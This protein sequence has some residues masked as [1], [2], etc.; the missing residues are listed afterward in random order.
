MYTYGHTFLRT[1]KHTCA[2]THTHKHVRAYCTLQQEE[3]LQAREQA[4]AN[5]ERELRGLTQSLQ[6]AKAEV[7][8]CV[9]GLTQSL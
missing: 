4:L 3:E 7:C 6:S 8:V 9:C 5:D 2:L 1:P